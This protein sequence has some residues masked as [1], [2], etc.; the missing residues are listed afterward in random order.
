MQSFPNRIRIGFDT[1]VRIML[2][3][4]EATQQFKIE[5]RVVQLAQ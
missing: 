2:H 4:D 1:V 3:A 5:K